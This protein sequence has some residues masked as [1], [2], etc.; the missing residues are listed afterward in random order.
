MD[1]ICCHDI[2][3]CLFAFS[4]PTPHRQA[5]SSVVWRLSSGLDHLPLVLP[6]RSADRIPL[7]TLRRAAVALAAPSTPAFGGAGSEPSRAAHPA[8]GLLEAV[9]TRTPRLGHLDALGGD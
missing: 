3:Q 5:D 9:R 8:S 7:C 6:G 2:P 4:G 1:S